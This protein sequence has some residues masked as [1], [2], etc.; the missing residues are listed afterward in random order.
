MSAAQKKEAA[1]DEVEEVV[2][3]VV[4]EEALDQET[5]EILEEIEGEAATEYDDLPDDGF[6]AEEPADEGAD[7]L[8]A[9]K[10]EAAEANDRYVR[11]QAEWDN[12]RKRTAT[13]REA[14]RSRAAE[15]LVSDLLPVLDDL[16]RAIEHAQE[17]G[18]GGSLTE[19]VEAV[20]TKCLDTLAKHKVVPLTPLNEPFDANLHQA[21]GTRE[22][23]SVCEE[24]V[25]EVLQRGYLMGDKVI[26]PAMVITSTGGP[27]RP[28]ETA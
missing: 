6:P 7:E 27:Q 10:R 14:E 22:D 28:A 15:S 9:A 21:V 12:F 2:G 18:E 4:D 16:D 1:G 19:G 20:R 25:V 23:D 3:E 11:L 17:S 13:E 26:R 5:D 8:E 24:T